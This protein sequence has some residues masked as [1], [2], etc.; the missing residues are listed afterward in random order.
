MQK[1]DDM[2]VTPFRMELE[3][4]KLLVEGFE[5]SPGRKTRNEQSV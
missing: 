4:K 2:D 5:M 3:L 1:E